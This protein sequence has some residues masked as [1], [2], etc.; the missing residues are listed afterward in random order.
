M[1]AVLFGVWAPLCYYLQTSENH[2]NDE[3]TDEVKKLNREVDEQ[4]REINGLG[5]LRGREFYEREERPMST[6]C[7]YNP[8]F[9]LD[10]G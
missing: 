5:L 4:R 2:S 6:S 9:V 1:C 3:L 8:L 7:R 10:T